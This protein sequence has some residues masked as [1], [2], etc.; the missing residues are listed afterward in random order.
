[1]TSRRHFLTAAGTGLAATL[2]APPL[3]WAQ[4]DA[5][6][7][8][9]QAGHLRVALEFGRPPWGFK[10]AQLKM[11]GSDMETAEL[12]AADLGVKLEI[13]EVTGP[14]RIP[15]LQTNKADI[16]L[17]TFSIT[18]ERLKVIDFSTPY[19]SAV[20]MVG[21]PKS[22][23]LRQESD[24]RGKRVGV[25]RATTGDVELTKR[26]KDLGVEIVRFDDEATNMTALASGQLDIV[27]QE[28]AVL[29]AVAQ[30]NPQRQL[31]AK[32]VFTQ[33]PVGIGLRKGEPA[34][35]GFVDSWVKRRLA[36]G[37]LN[38]IYRKFHGA[39][40]SAEVLKGGA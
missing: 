4:S 21:A 7:A 10:D 34:L 24:L 26:A 19:A 23:P 40:L 37:R 36:D 20:Q 17:S 32:F 25:T 14:N 38:A 22:L 6:A 3:A 2:A 12:L 15:F 31:E 18:P 35:K 8:I 28:P 16:V 27:V 1:M 11:T 29:S 5:L 30:R 39:D 33:F 9:R 13:V